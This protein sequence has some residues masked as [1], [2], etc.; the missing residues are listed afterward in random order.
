MAFALIVWRWPGV[1]RWRW[2]C[3][4]RKLST[5]ITTPSRSTAMAPSGKPAR[6]SISCALTRRLMTGQTAV[7]GGFDASGVGLPALRAT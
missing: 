5:P 2:P 1:T 3:T 7:D 6:P 4:P